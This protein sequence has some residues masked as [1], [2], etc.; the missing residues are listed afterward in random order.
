M[1]D[2]ITGEEFARTYIAAWS[3]EDADERRGL[4]DQLYSEEA[5]FFAAEPGDAAVERRGRTEIFDNISDV[6]ERLTQRS[7]LATTGTGVS[8]NHDLLR[9]SWEMTTADGGTAL[10]GMNLLT[11]NI[12]GMIVRDYIFIG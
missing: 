1:T 7:G 2:G 9:V 3:T 10:R 4:V 12:A 5:E 8:V 11:L 6:N